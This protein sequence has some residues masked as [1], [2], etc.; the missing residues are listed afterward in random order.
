M[1]VVVGGGGSALACSPSASHLL[2]AAIF[3]TVLRRCSQPTAKSPST[4][5]SRRLFLLRFRE[6]KLETAERV[7]AVSPNISNMGLRA[8]RPPP[9]PEWQLER[10]EN[11]NEKNPELYAF[12]KQDAMEKLPDSQIY[13]MFFYTQDSLSSLFSCRVLLRV[14]D[15]Q[16]SNF[17]ITV[18][19]CSGR[20]QSITY[21]NLSAEHLCL[22]SPKSHCV[23]AIFAVG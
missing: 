14:V 5:L 10:T 7:A 4:L 20:I 2:T 21:V 13:S 17:L 15:V 12:R 18:K 6:R 3:S 23:Y 9:D 11:W 16:R 22:F 19:M 1:V 8:S